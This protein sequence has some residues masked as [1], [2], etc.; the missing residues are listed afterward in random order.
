MNELEPCAQKTQGIASDLAER[1]RTRRLSPVALTL[2]PSPERPLILAA[3]YAVCAFSVA[4]QGITFA[5]LAAWLGRSRGGESAA[6]ER[7]SP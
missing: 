5:P 2:P 4:V 7:P 6:V 1:L 3:T